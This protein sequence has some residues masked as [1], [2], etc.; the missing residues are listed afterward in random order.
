M[1]LSSIEFKAEGVGGSAWRVLPPEVFQGL[2]VEQTGWKCG[3]NLLS[4]NI[5]LCSLCLYV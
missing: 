2:S 4:L 5:P 1:C 3:L